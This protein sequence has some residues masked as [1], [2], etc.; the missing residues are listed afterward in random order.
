MLK[1][2]LKYDLKHVFKYWWIGAIACFALATLGGVGLKIDDMSME[3]ELPIVINIFSGLSIIIA[4]FGFVI[5]ST[6]S[7]VLVIIRT[8]KNF[9]SDEG[10][11]TFTLPVKRSTLL[12]S[13]LLTSYIVTCVTLITALFN[14]FIM[15]CIPY[16][17]DIFSRDTIIAIKEFVRDVI[18]E[19]GVPYFI[20]YVIEILVI[21]TL[22]ITLSMLVILLCM[23]VGSLIAKKGKIIASFALYY[24]FTNVSTSVIFVYMTVVAPALMSWLND[25]SDANFNIVLALLL[26]VL[27]AFLLMICTLAYLAQYRLLDKKLNLQ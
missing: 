27:I 25:I 20:F 5:F 4:L 19:M 1:K 17:K 6:F 24:A 7:E 16:Y 21:I 11:L 22:A 18:C 13:K 8:Y 23:S 15:M 9:Y 26:S 10:Y 12:V 2:V 14:F 3:K